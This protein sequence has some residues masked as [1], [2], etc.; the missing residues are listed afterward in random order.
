MGAIEHLKTLCCLG[1]KPE[2]AMIAV[3][4]LLHEIIPHGWS[5]LG[6]I[7]PDAAI[8]SYYCEIPE[9]EAVY[10]ERVWRFMDDPSALAYLWYSLVDNVAIGWTLHRQVKANYLGTG[11]Y[12]EI[13]SPFD[14]GWMLDAMIGDGGKTIGFVHLTRPRSARPFTSDD[15]QRLDRLRP[16]LA[17][18]LRRTASD[19]APQD[20]EILTNTSGRII[21]SGQL[22]ATA[23]ARL[24]HQTASVEFL[25]RILSGGPTVSM[26]N[27]PMPAYDELPAP[28]LKL[29]HRIIGAAKGA[30]NTPPRAQI[31]TDYGLVTLE[32]QWLLPVGTLPEDAAKDPKSCLISVMIE[33]REHAIAHAAR[34]LRESGASPQQTRVGIL[35]AMGKTKP[36]IADELGLKSSSVDDH[37]KKLYQTLDVHNAAALAKTVWTDQKPERP[38]QIFR[39]SG[40]A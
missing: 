26:R 22:I 5:R 33:L 24:V 8:T 37:A 30:S 12:R 7:A 16:W 1:L 17:H 23:D 6:L 2:S 27:V 34:I 18:A 28:I 40:K 4:P 31:S 14:A 11:Y 29:L 35:L 32:A 38:L 3:V 15:V 21:R 39:L 9:T 25:L 10:R 36:I 20:D 19:D 13:E